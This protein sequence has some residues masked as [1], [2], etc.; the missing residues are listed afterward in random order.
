M[1]RQVKYLQV[2]IEIQMLA[3]DGHNP[4]TEEMT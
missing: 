3:V 4:A 2:R 1:L